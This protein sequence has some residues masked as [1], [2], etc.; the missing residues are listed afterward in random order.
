MRTAWATSMVV[1]ALAIL[2][3]PA[4]P[5]VVEG[6][7]LDQDNERPVGGAIVAL[8]EEDGDERRRVLA[9]SAGRFR[10]VPPEA[11][12]YYLLAERFGYFETRSPLI[13]FGTEGRA[14]IDLLMVP[15][16]VGLEGLEVSVEELAAQELGQL[17]LTPAQLGNRWIG[18]EEIDAIAVKRD[19]GVILER[20]AQAGIQIIRPENLTIGSDNLGLC[21]SLQRAR[22]AGGGGR[23]AL[24]VLD[25]IPISPV[26]ALDIDPSSI[27]SIA[28]L[29]P[30]QASTFSGTVG[31]SGAV[32]V[33]T[34]RGG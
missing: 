4:A 24:I 5:Q 22:T 28:I 32:L 12:E 20:T 1:C 8:V 34:R 6:R 18:R 33:W 26:Q 23:C 13:A 3:S 25:G 17:G 2:A 21:V 19:M 29:D 9:D 16:P 30:I 27:Q 11:G 31:G 15:R 10:I 14:A 7:V